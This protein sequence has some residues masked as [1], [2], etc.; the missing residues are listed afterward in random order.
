M[1]SLAAIV[2]RMRCKNV[3][4]CS[5]GGQGFPKVMGGFDRELLDA[6]ACSETGVINKD[7]SVNVIKTVIQCP[8]P[9]PKATRPVC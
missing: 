8:L 4:V 5:Y 7:S 3:T 2:H 6:T 9:T 1:N